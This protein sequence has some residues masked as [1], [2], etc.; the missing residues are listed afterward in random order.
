MKSRDAVMEVKI[1]G[2]R[3]TSCLSLAAEK[4]SREQGPGVDGL[5]IRRGRPQRR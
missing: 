5:W 3:E 2:P 4:F 1:F